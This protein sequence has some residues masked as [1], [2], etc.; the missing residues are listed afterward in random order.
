MRCGRK[1]K[2][3]GTLHMNDVD[4]WWNYKNR[5]KNA[6]SVITSMNKLCSSGAISHDLILIVN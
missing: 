6:S 5:M 1:L 3:L 2:L 4:N